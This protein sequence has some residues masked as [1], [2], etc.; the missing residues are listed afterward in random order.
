MLKDIK[1][2]GGFFDEEKQLELFKSGE[3]LSILYF[4]NWI[5]SNN[6]ERLEKLFLDNFI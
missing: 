4:S 5:F 3:R 6:E 1:F 2:T